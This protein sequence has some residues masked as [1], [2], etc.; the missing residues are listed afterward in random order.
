MLGRDGSTL[1][2]R[3]DNRHPDRLYV[4]V[5]GRVVLDGVELLRNAA[6]SFESFALNSVAQHF[7]REE[8]LLTGDDRSDDI[9]YLF[10]N[11][12]PA[13][14]AYNLK[15]RDRKSTRLN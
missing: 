3:Y 7:L 8:K 15:D 6:Y 12:K 2:Y 5:A 11:D 1:T 13:L 9:E 10:K 14:A 4:Y